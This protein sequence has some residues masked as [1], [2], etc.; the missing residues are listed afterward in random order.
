MFCRWKPIERYLFY[1]SFPNAENEKDYKKEMVFVLFRYIPPSHMYHYLHKIKCLYQKD[2][3]LVNLYQCDDFLLVLKRKHVYQKE[4]FNCMIGICA[5]N[6]MNSPYFISTFYETQ[7]DMYAITA[8][9]YV[10][11]ITFEKFMLERFQEDKSDSFRTF[12]ILFLQILFSLDHAQLQ[13]SFTH[14]DLHL[15]NIMIEPTDASCLYFPM[16]SLKYCIDN[17]KYKIKILDFEFSCVQL[18]DKVI[19]NVY[20][21]IFQYGYLSIFLPGVD[22]LRLMMEL[23]VI[24]KKNSKLGREV[25]CFLDSIFVSFYHF[26]L[27]ESWGSQLKKHQKNF[28][29]MTFTKRIF[30]C[31]FEL[32]LHLEKLHNDKFPFSKKGIESYY[33]IIESDRV[34]KITDDLCDIEDCL[35]FFK[36]ELETKDMISKLK[37]EKWSRMIKSLEQICGWRRL[38]PNGKLCDEKCY[39]YLKIE[40]IE[41]SFV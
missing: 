3:I 4:D 20:E 10:Q 18:N 28:F 41:T 2:T 1:N 36:Q 40:K 19:A 16:G 6:P 37:R 26:H 29:N 9:E 23:R 38:F 14:F 7:Q 34:P 13:I 22:M 27:M 35:K 5:V 39:P 24:P 32:I 8:M 12:L 21:S 31:P 11:G 15:R 17:P 25:D 33:P 30:Q